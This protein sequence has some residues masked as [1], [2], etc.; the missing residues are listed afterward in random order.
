MLLAY[1]LKT[2]NYLDVSVPHL[3]PKD[4]YDTYF[5]LLTDLG[6][7]AFSSVQPE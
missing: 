1:C 4:L 2:Y 7:L 5:N 6:S 3:I